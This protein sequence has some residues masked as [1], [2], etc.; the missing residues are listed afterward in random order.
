MISF[1]V[2]HFA[3]VAAGGGG[4]PL[5]TVTPTSLDVSSGQQTYTLTGADLTDDI[6]VTQVGTGGNP[7][8]PQLSLTG[9]GGTWFASVVAPHSGGVVNTTIYVRKNPGVTLFSG[10]YTADVKNN[11]AGAAEKIVAVSYTE[12]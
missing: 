3:P 1:P 2:C 8:A 4:T 12:P 7:L 11:S 9:A 6:A 10:V 5:I